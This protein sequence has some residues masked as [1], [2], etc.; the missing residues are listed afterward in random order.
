MC[1]EPGPAQIA[2]MP[3][4]SALLPWRTLHL[5]ARLP[6]EL[7]NVSL[8]EADS[9]ISSLFARLQIADGA[10][11]LPSQASG[12]MQRRTALVRALVGGARLFLLDE[13]FTGLDYDVKIRAQSILLS[14]QRERN[15]GV[16]LVTHDLEDA[17]ALCTR[18]IILS[19]RPATIKRAIEIDG[20]RER[21]DLI[22]IRTS[23]T[24]RHL[25]SEVWDELQYLAEPT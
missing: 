12:G 21:Q 19:R 22:A 6:A 5:N 8:P 14:H 13:P 2:Y 18:L 4:E 15:G 1:L 23:S 3:Q 20:I 7:W 24:F 17:I 9:D 11:Q 16:V 25:V 10:Q